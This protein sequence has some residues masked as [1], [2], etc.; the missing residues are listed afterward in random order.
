MRFYRAAR[1]AMAD[2]AVVGSQN[3]IGP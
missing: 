2:F 3:W 1:T